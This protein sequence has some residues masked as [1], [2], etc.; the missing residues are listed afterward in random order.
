MVSDKS[1]WCLVNYKWIRGKWK[2]M[3]LGQEKF[4]EATNKSGENIPLLYLQ[5]NKAMSMLGMH[6][7]PDGND[8]DQVQ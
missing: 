5:A 7:A 6:L 8:N 2:C 1:A 3:N 4:L